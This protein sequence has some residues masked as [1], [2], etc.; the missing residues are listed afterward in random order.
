MDL[1]QVGTEGEMVHETVGDDELRPQDE[2]KNQRRDDCG[3]QTSYAVMFVLL[4]IALF[5]AVGHDR[6]YSYLNDHDV[7]QVVLPQAWV[8]RIGNAFAFLFKIALVS[9]IAVAYAQGFWFFVRRKDLK[10]GSLD[11]MFGVLANPLLFLNPEFFRKTIVLFSLAVISW[12]L[13]ITAVL[14]PGSLTGSSPL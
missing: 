12:I 1:E 6:F 13:P 4:L 2:V 5:A 3:I 14:A 7:A 8:I 9:T 11:A 10:I